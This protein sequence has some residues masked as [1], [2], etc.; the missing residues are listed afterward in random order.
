MRLAD[1][2]RDG[3]AGL[4]AVKLQRE[5]GVA[6]R[7]GESDVWRE[8]VRFCN[9]ETEKTKKKK[10]IELVRDIIKD[11]FTQTQLPRGV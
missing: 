3:R 11:I 5:A 4:K 2:D 6:Q 1:G 8:G 10:K 7:Q 9:K